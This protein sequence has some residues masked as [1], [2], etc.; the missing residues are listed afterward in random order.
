MRF[1]SQKIH[2]PSNHYTI[3]LKNSILC[4][5]KTPCDLL[6]ISFVNNVNDSF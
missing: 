5:L 1:N 4:R 2:I 3:T 6:C